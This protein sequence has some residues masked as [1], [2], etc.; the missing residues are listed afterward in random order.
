MRVT[1]GTFLLLILLLSGGLSQAADRFDWTTPRGAKIAVDVYNYGADSVLV[2]APGQGCSPRLDLYDA[3]G[4]EAKRKGFTLV[5]LYWAYCVA[6]PANGAPSE[7]LKFEKEDLLTALKNTQD[8]FHYQESNTFI[9][10]KS[11]GTWVSFEVFKDRPLL[12]GLVLLTPVCTDSSDEKNVRN[13]FSENYLG[14]EK[15]TRP[16]LLVQGNA[17][18]LCQNTH[19]QEFVQDK[20]GNFVP[21]V[22]RGGHGLG[23]ANSD[24]TFDATVTAKNL[25]VISHWIFTW[26]P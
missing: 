7:D 8:L 19:F 1:A 6:D 11:L 14:L 13:A 17:D 12:R 25:D 24:G 18:P 23:I 16:V 21:L 15:E 20:P 2:L 4:E 10:G 26:L 5:R 22:V 3:I 9:G